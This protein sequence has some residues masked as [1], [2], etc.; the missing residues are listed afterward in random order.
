MSKMMIASLGVAALAASASAQTLST[1][2]IADLTT[3]NDRTGVTAPTFGT[4][5]GIV[6]GTITWPVVVENTMGFDIARVAI[7]I[8]RDPT[9]MYAPGEFEQI[10]FQ[11]PSTSDVSDSPVPGD[12][13][14]PFVVDAATLSDD[15]GNL[16]SNQRL[17]FFFSSGAPHKEGDALMYE[18]TIDNPTDRLYNFSFE[19]FP[20]PTPGSAF[21]AGMAGLLVSRRQR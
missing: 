9:E 16:A 19:F 5:L 12:T 7:R 17:D 10:A 1:Q 2:N 20:V 21:V 15:N 4:E 8:E 14:A 11:T 6:S 18:F 3:P 13:D